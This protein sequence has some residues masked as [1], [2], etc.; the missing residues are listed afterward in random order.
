MSDNATKHHAP[1]AAAAW[2]QMS[3]FDKYNQHNAPSVGRLVEVN[4]IR[5]FPSA[6]RDIPWVE[7]T[8]A[9]LPNV[10]GITVLPIVP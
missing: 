2:S 10:L 8:A 3:A 6:S 9:A 4:M 7:F 1:G 5:M